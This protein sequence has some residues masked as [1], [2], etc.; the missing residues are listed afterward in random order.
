MVAVQQEPQEPGKKRTT[1]LKNLLGWAEE[2]V[3]NRKRL[4]YR[5]FGNKQRQS[6]Q[7]FLNELTLVGIPRPAPRVV[8][9]MYKAD[10]DHV[11]SKFVGD[12]VD[13]VRDEQAFAQFKLMLKTTYIEA[14]INGAP[15]DVREY[16]YLGDAMENPL[17]MLLA[18]ETPEDFLTEQAKYELKLDELCKARD[19]LDEHIAYM[20]VCG[21][22]AAH[23]IKPMMRLETGRYSLDTRGVLALSAPEEEG[24]DNDEQE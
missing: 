1:Y 19:G 24:A 18:A 7:G 8:W 13:E 11:I 23:H 17:K 3:K 10:H 9:E 15:M 16:E 22:A 14:E 5:G 2:Y 6:V 20:Q 12:K 4:S 21:I